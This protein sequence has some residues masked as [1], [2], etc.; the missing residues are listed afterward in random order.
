MTRLNSFGRRAIIRFLAVTLTACFPGLALSQD[1]LSE[2]K[3]LGLKG[4]TPVAVVVR[5]NTPREIFTPK[6]W[7]AMIEVQLSRDLPK[8][9]RTDVDKS[10]AWL[11]LSVVTTDLGGVFEL[12]LYRWT[13]I[14]D[15]GEVVFSKVWSESRMVFGAVS[16]A[17]GREALETLVTTFAADY[18]RG[19]L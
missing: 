13:R 17:S 19:N 5:P 4:L 10:K 2:Q 11:E 18:L 6:E 9:G 7:G 1:I 14:L 15:S 3:I 12:S 8:L 16:R